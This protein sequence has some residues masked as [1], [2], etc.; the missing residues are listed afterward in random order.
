VPFHKLFCITSCRPAGEQTYPA[1][2]VASNPTP[3]FK[4]VKYWP[5]TCKVLEVSYF[6]ALKQFNFAVRLWNNLIMKG[7]AE[8][9]GKKEA[10]LFPSF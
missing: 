1:N 6:L 3:N 10:R 8:I 9:L 2:S 4:I 5:V 7:T